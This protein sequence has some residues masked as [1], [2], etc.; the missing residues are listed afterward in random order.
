MTF[1]QALARIEGLLKPSMK[2]EPDFY[3]E[4][5]ELLMEHA[6]SIV[7]LAKI[8]AGMRAEIE[9]TQLNTTGYIPKGYNS[10]PHGSGHSYKAGETAEAYDKLMNGE[11][12]V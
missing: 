12:G 4:C 9:V 10:K 7:Q 5:Q 2:R 6:D 11:E 1:A 3:H 8:A